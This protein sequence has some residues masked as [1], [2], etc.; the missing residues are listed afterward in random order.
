MKDIKALVFDLD[1]TLYDRWSTLRGVCYIVRKA[2]PDWWKDEL[3]YEQIYEEFHDSDY[4]H[5]YG[6]WEEVYTDFQRKGIFKNAPD[7]NTFR[8]EVLE[9][10]K[11]VAVPIPFVRE[12]MV[13]F[14]RQGYKLG[15]I[16]NGESKLQ[17]RKI[18]LL[19]FI[20][21][22]DKIL[23]SGDLDCAKPDAKIFRRMAEEL[24]VKMD[25]FLFIGD[26]P[27]IDIQGSYNAGCTPV[28]VKTSGDWHYQGIKEPEIQIN[29]VTELPE[30]LEKMKNH[31]VKRNA[32][33]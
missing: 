27:V 11:I 29:D 32:N 13:E 23:V 6:G 14:R 5:I 26:G 10:F 20:P 19:D 33:K 24:K 9:G 2:H 25:E 7:V 4:N 17:W 15:I 1:R 3:C 21:L 31:M 16:T 12:M 28:F 8:D 18:E 22:F 30:L